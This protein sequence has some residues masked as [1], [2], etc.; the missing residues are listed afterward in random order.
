VGSACDNCPSDANPGQSDLDLDGLGDVCDPCPLQPGTGQG[1]TCAM[2]PVV[3]LALSTSSPAG[4]GS[5][6]VTWTTAAEFD[7]D[8]FNLTSIDAQGQRTQLNTAP[9]PCL[10]CT[11]GRGASYSVIIAKHK[12]G[13]NLFLEV[14]HQGGT[15]QLYGPAVKN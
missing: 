10:E 15:T 6:L 14:V 13:K 1:G 12:S 9:I 4:K 7:I 5:G 8:H 11:S 3:D 2:P